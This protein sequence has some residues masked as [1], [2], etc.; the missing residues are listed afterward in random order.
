[1]I[2]GLWDPQGSAFASIDYSDIKVKACQIYCS[3]E[4]SRPAADND[5]VAHMNSFS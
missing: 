1:M 4:A 3:R 5:A 2:M